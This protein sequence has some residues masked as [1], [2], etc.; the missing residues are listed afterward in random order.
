M[1]SMND[2]GLT[3]VNTHTPATLCRCRKHCT[4]ACNV[5]L[6]IAPAICQYP[7]VILSSICYRYNFCIVSALTP[8]HRTGAV[9]HNLISI[10]VVTL[11]LWAL[12]WRLFFLSL[13]VENV[14]KNRRAEFVFL[15]SFHRWK[16]GRTCLN[17][18][19]F[20]VHCSQK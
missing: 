8:I 17:K 10:I 9:C 16:I 12:S 18:C 7:G 20:C 2:V 19:V 6:D 15:H 13:V 14:K 3:T 4:Y 1:L 11:S 5:S